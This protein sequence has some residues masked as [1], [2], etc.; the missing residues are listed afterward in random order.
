MFGIVLTCTPLVAANSIHVTADYEYRIQKTDETI[1]IDGVLSESIWSE[2][3]LATEFWMSYP[4]DDKR[5]GDA[6]RTEVRLMSDDKA[7]AADD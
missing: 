6:L 3:P 4:V 7:D 1:R 2:V 5:V